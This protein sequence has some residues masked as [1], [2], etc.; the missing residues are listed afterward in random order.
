MD[1]DHRSV[2]RRF[3]MTRR[4]IAILALLVFAIPFTAL[5]DWD[6]SQA[7]KW[8]QLPDETELGIDVNASYDFILADDFECIDH[9]PIIEIHIWGSWM[10]DVLPFE[11]PDS[12][13]FTLSF[14]KDIPDS[15]SGTGY[16]MPGE[17]LWYRD[18]RPGEFTSRIH[19]QGVPEGW[20]DPPDGYLYPA[21]YT[22][23]QYNFYIPEEDAFVQNGTPDEPKVYW[24]DVKATPAD[25]QTLFGWK[26]SLDHWNDDAVWGLGDE[27]YLGPWYELRYPPGHQYEG[28]SIDLAFV[29]V[30]LEEELD[31]GDAPDPPFPTY[32]THSG[33]SHVIGGPWLGDLTDAPDPEVGGQPDPNALGDDNDGN[34]DE[35]GV[36]IPVLTQGTSSTINFE[37]GGMGGWVEGWI[38]FNGDGAWA[39]PAEQVY[40]AFHNPGI[41]GF[42]VST[43]PGAVVG[44]TFARFRISTIGGLTPTG[45]APDGEVEDYEVYIEEG[46]AGWK[47]EQRPDLSEMG[48]D[49]EATEPFILAD[50]Y[51]CTEQGRI[52]MIEVWG[53]W[54]NDYLPYEVDPT[55]V[56]FVLSIHADIP[57]SMS[58][59]GYSM[60]GDP[61]WHRW[62][63][64]PEFEAEVY[65]SNIVEGWMTP[66]D[67]YLF[68]ADWTCW[69][70]RFYV[71][72]EE[73]FFQQGTED[74]PTV[75]WLDLQAYP[76][77]PAARFGWKT[78]TEHWNDDAVWGEGSEPYLG[79]WYELRYPPGHQYEGESIDLAFR[80]MNEPTSGVPAEE[81]GPE[82]FGLLRNSPNPFTSA[83]ALRF[84]LP[85][86]GGHVRLEIYDVSGRRVKTL[87]DGFRQGGVHSVDW[88]GRNDAGEK[89]P[90]GVY[91][92]RLTLGERE[93]SKKTLLIR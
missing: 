59:T 40:S 82:G 80:L 74:A 50:D 61:L 7:A 65:A 25:P 5:A 30:G 72:V 23:W 60:P 66:P 46:Q 88:S 64:Y 43:P 53:S 81:A 36:Q 28:E 57:D 54:L 11:H 10:N 35:D 41:Y 18:F 15:E 78:S 9:G 92:Q 38:D 6:P 26:T 49:V 13:M 62:F 84:S 33:A 86:D 39:T 68:P 21:D 44:Q 69:L 85:A 87:V 20:L 42:N 75:Y 45:Q 56:D 93:I 2:E 8:V 71:P 83:T 3:G 63:A 48:I 27:P 24:L 29:L 19:M 17:V 31:W 90:A 91:F 76:H 1:K 37:V 12:V 58:G 70:Y 55:A 79:P 89:L 47:W 14:H 51:L 34:D 73:A 16:S 32:A 77:D 67:S 4:L 22:I 52:T